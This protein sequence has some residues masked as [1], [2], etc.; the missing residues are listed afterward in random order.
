MKKRVQALSTLTAQR[1]GETLTMHLAAS[2]EGISVVLSAKRNEGWTH[3]YFVS[4]VLQGAELN[5]P[6]LEKLVLTFVHAARRLRRYFQAHMITVLKNTPIKKML[7]EPEKTGRVAKWAIKLGEHDIVF[8]RRNEKETSANF[9]VEIPFEDNEKKEKPKEVPYLN[10][11]WRHYTDGASNS[12]RSG[13]GLML[14][15][16]EGKEY[17]YALRYEFETT[18][19]E[20]EYEALLAAPPQTDKIIKEIHEGSCGFNAEPCSLVFIIT[21]Q[22]YYWPSMHREV[23]TAIQ[24]YKKCKEQSAIRKSGTSRSIVAGSTD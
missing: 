8:L 17:T 10:S 13:T 21:K 22:G 6:A 5:Y 14:I 18:N 19:N 1:V 7:T 4:R 11:K 2:R 24:D 3:I 9:L 15:D 20:A 12:D 23:A 16:P